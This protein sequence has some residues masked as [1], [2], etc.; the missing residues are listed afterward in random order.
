MH[1]SY[2]IFNL[3][4][5]WIGRPLGTRLIREK[6]IFLSEPANFYASDR[7]GISFQTVQNCQKN[8]KTFYLIRLVSKWKETIRK[9]YMSFLVFHF[10]NLKFVA[11]DSALIQHQV[12]KLTF[13]LN[14]GEVPWK[15]AKLESRSKF[16]WNVLYDLLFGLISANF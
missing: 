11:I 4:F 6:N 16:F 5:V 10:W 1:C 12:I 15:A 2:V 14:V 9:G 3:N 8:G 7:F 13:F